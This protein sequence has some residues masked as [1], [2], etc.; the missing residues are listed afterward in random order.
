MHRSCPFLLHVL[1]ISKE[2]MYFPLGFRC[3]VVLI[4]EK[5]GEG[6]LTQINAAMRRIDL[7]CKLLAPV[8][9]GFLM[10]SVS[11]LSS[12]VLIA[13]WNVTSVG[14]EYW[15]LHHVYMAIPILQQK[16]TVDPASTSSRSQ[17]LDETSTRGEVELGILKSGNAVQVQEAFSCLRMSYHFSCQ[18]RDSYISFIIKIILCILLTYFLKVEDTEEIR[19]L[20]GREAPT[21]S[22]QSVFVEKLKH[23]PLVDGWATYMHQEAMLAGLALALLYFTVLRCVFYCV[24]ELHELKSSPGGIVFVFDKVFPLYIFLCCLRKPRSS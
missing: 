8:A 16:H 2:L 24:S 12:A 7:S 3:R 20:G 19:L 10:S 21:R 14:V 4:A 6:F 15:L 22:R 11:V 1:S 5:Q 13:V 23:L 18:F 9:V 17:S